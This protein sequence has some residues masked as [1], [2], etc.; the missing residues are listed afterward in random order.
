[1]NV[2]QKTNDDVNTAASSNFKRDRLIFT[3]LSVINLL[4]FVD[5]GIVPGSTEEF[6]AF[7]LSSTSG[8]GSTPTDALLGFLQSAFIVGLISGS[9]LFGHLIHRWGRFAL[10]RIGLIIW[11]I[12]VLSA[13]LAGFA[14]SYALLLIARMFS[15]FGEASLQCTIPPWIERHAPE[16]QRGTWLAIFFTAIPVGTALGYAYSAAISQSMGWE[17]AFI[18]EV[19]MMAPLIAFLFFVPEDVPH[20]HET[21]KNS[22]EEDAEEEHTVELAL[23]NTH[24]QPTAEY[25]EIGTQTH[26]HVASSHEIDNTVSSPH[27]PSM[28][29]EVK[30]LVTRPVFL[31]LIFT[32]AAETAVLIGLSTFGSAFMIS[33]GFF[34]SETA[35]STMFGVLISLAGIIATP[36][37]GWVLDKAILHERRKVTV[38]N[39][40]ETINEDKDI[41]LCIRLSIEHTYWAIYV[42]TLCLAIIFFLYSRSTYLLM[43]TIGCAFCFFTNTGL[44]MAIM[45]SVP[46]ANRSLGI[47]IGTVCGH[48]FGDVPSPIIAG[49]MKDSLAPH[50]VASADNDSNDG[51]SVSASPAC[52]AEGDGIR[53]TMLFIALWMFWAVF[54]TAGAWHFQ[55]KQRRK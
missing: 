5:R 28:W 41:D 30:L 21:I 36:L 11:S 12:A 34:D 8:N 53:L 32:S 40:S 7:I 25:G 37:G 19:L 15:G 49:W 52:R 1:M 24:L 2:I 42:G 38:H 14:N 16:S 13:G 45:L 18:L 31:C 9:L 39:S 3:V 50:C 27:A 44:N 47:A 43:I 4:N 51:D 55:L 35:A 26:S 17:W 29:E 46:E 54:L 10:T 33:L 48:A 23:L 22:Q 20:L 6:N